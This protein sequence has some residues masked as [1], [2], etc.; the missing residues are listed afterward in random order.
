MAFGLGKIRSDKI[1]TSMANQS[2]IT[3]QPLIMNDSDLTF[4]IKGDFCPSEKFDLKTKQN[5]NVIRYFGS[6][7]NQAQASGLSYEPITL[8]GK[9]DVENFVRRTGELKALSY[10]LKNFIGFLDSDWLDTAQNIENYAL[11]NI[12]LFIKE[13]K[14]L[15]ASGKYIIF[16]SALYSPKGIQDDIEGGSIGELGYIGSSLKGII[17]DFNV[18]IFQHGIF[19]YELV[20]QPLS[21]S[22][23]EAE[24]N[25]TASIVGAFKKVKNVSKL[26]TDTLNA[27]VGGALEI[28]NQ[29]QSEFITNTLAE[30][31]NLV[32]T[33]F[34]LVKKAINLADIGTDITE[35]IYST[36]DN[37]INKSNE[38]KN[39]AIKLDSA[40]DSITKDIQSLNWPDDVQGE[41]VP[42]SV[43]S[44]LGF[45]A[46][47]EGSLQA[48]DIN[49]GPTYNSLDYYFKQNK[50]KTMDKF[51]NQESEDYFKDLQI[52][53]EQNIQDRLI[54]QQLL[55]VT[56]TI[57]ELQSLIDR[58]SVGWTEHLVV[59][60]ETLRSISLK[61]Y[62][63]ADRWIDIAKYNDFDGDNIEEGII[64]KI[65]TL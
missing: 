47:K 62:N 12:Q 7:I 40:Y 35:Q 60:G 38:I 42:A 52:I 25:T 29:A 23:I 63:D 53:S 3:I 9:F 50:I 1:A 15:Q 13:L 65:P 41:D 26:C 27:Y 54:R 61:Y 4:W 24:I 36:C 18:T 22:I 51:F 37:I 21:P 30:F 57:K 45:I 59:Y 8:T 31:N 5:I 32:N 20:I 28:I 46:D 33:G 6:D 10:D 14:N 39:Q 16:D 64:I 48:N 56:F 19:E 17:T 34:D 2:I 55:N 11:T 58:V 44:A 49:Y 43:T